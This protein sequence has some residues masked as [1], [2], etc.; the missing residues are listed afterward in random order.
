MDIS[1]MVFGGALIGTLVSVWGNIKSI[2]WK[3]CTIFVKKV[4]FTE[5]C[6]PYILRYLR[7]N[8]KYYN[9]HDR[10]YDDFFFFT[11]NNKIYE[12]VAAEIFKN[13]SL[14]FFNDKIPFF[15]FQSESQVNNATIRNRTIYYI[16]GTLDID[17]LIKESMEYENAISLEQQYENNNRFFIQYIPGKKDSTNTGIIYDKKRFDSKIVSHDLDLLGLDC[18]VNSID[19]II[20]TEENR[21]IVKLAELWKKNKEWYKQKDIPWKMGWLLHGPPGTGKT[22]LSRRIAEHLNIPIFVFKLGMLGDVEFSEEWAKMQAS[23]P[24]LALIE[25][26]DNIFHGRTNVVSADLALEGLSLLHGDNKDKEDKEDSPK[27]PRGRRV[28]FDNLLNTLDG[29]ERYEGIFTIIT[30]NHIDKIDNALLNRPGRI[31]KVFELGYLN[32]EGKLI[33]IDKILGDMPKAKTK[34]L[35]FI[36]TNSSKHL[37]PAQLQEKCTELALKEFYENSLES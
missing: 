20:L 18:L 33:M 26:F 11:K 2:G 16:R 1:K 6:S 24:C 15:Y 28:S 9:L 27:G 10:K 29:A 32:N 19:K 14:I 5:T 3:L 4:T 8:Y 35:E 17:K 34:A 31:D 25:D 23:I 12:R 7:N 37:T 13:C 21:N 22:L 36:Q 30:T